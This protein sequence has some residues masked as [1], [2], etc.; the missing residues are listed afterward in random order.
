MVIFSSSVKFDSYE[1]Y[2]HECEHLQNVY[3]TCMNMVDM[4]KRDVKELPKYQFPYAQRLCADYHNVLYNKHVM[5]NK[6]QRY[7]LL[8]AWYDKKHTHYARYLHLSQRAIECGRQYHVLAFMDK[9]LSNRLSV[10]LHTYHEYYNSYYTQYYPMKTNYRRNSFAHVQRIHV[11]AHEQTRTHFSKWQHDETTLPIYNHDDKYV[12]TI[13][14]D[15]VD[16]MKH[17]MEEYYW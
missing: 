7:A 4:A 14:R 17:Y 12:T 3:H 6:Y 10:M 15:D 2:A 8:F 16:A 11:V 5:Y 13:K 1:Q 9:M